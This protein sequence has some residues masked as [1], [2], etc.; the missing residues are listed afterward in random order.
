[1]YIAYQSPYSLPVEWASFSL[2]ALEWALLRPQLPFHDAPASGPRVSKPTHHH[3][4]PLQ[5]VGA[6]TLKLINCFKLRSLQWWLM[7]PIFIHYVPIIPKAIKALFIHDLP[8]NFICASAYCSSLT[9]FNARSR[10]EPGNIQW[11]RSR[12]RGQVWWLP[13]GYWAVCP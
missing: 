13:L 2:C 10:L 6:N 8:D 5:I 11:L 7:S 3:L 12:Y 4:V 1:M 9:V